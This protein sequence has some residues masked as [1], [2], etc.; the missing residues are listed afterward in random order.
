MNA[1]PCGKALLKVAGEDLANECKKLGSLKTGEIVSSGSGK[2]NCKRVYHVRSSS[3]NNGDGAL[4]IV[5]RFFLESCSLVHFRGKC[6]SV[7]TPP[8]AMYLYISCTEITNLLNCT[9][10]LTT[11]I[12]ISDPSTDYQKVLQ[13]T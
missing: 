5:V 8:F 2:L 7:L 9:Y 1:N 6:T 13:E 4:V 10:L 3:W 12:S 11:R